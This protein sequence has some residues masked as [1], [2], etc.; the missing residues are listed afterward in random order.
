MILVNVHRSFTKPRPLM[1][2]I[3]YIGGAHIKAAKPLPSDLQDFI[4]NSEHGVVY[5]S[6]GSYLQTSELPM[7]KIHIFLH[8][9][10]QLKQRVIWKFENESPPFEVPAN[11]LIRKWLPQSDI[12]AHPNIVLFIAH[13]GIWY[14]GMMKT[15]F[16]KP[17]LLSF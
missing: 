17:H 12:L 14:F 1:P 6:L 7:D 9:L 15:I 11:V 16:S 13:G 5:F 8:A 3:V 2:G 4:D 10:S